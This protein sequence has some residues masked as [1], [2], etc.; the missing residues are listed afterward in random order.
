MARVNRAIELLEQGQPIYYSSPSELSYEGG[1]QASQTWADYLVVE[2]EHGTFNLAGLDAFMKGLAASGPT[3]SGHRTPTV[4]TT[5]PTDGTDEHVMRANAWMVK[6]VLA[7]GVHGILLCHAETPGAVKVFVES[8]RYPF[9]TIG[10]GEGLDVGR[11]GAGGQGN[12]AAIWGISTEE[13]M[14]RADVWPLNPEGEI[15]LG[16]KIENKRALNNA[17]ATVRVPGIAFAEWGPGDM[18]LSHGYVDRDDP[19]YAEESANARTRV[20]AACDAEN[21]AFLDG[22]TPDNVA[23][24]IENGVRVGSGGEEVANIGRKYTNR[25]MPW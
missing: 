24:K 11:R 8:A 2:M 18:T 5:L 4:I 3:K 12:A 23:E 9:H 17:E 19:S 7:R 6:Q 20:K 1:V 21:I 15:F 14:K 25:T 22:V 10:V 13:Y 16:L